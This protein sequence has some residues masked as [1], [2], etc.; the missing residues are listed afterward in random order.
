MAVPIPNSVFDDVGAVPVIESCR[1]ESWRGGKLLASSVPV[2]SGTLTGDRSLTVPEQVTLTVPVEVDGVRWDPL[3]E[4]DPLACYGQQ[5]RIAV[6]L[7]VRRKLYWMPRAPVVITGTQRDGDTIT[8][9]ASS[10][11]HLVSEARL[12][13]PLQP[14]AGDTLKKLAR[15]LVEPGLPVRFDDALVDRAVPTSSLQWDDDRIGALY[16]LAGAW[17]AELS[18]HRDGYLLFSPPV[19]YDLDDWEADVREDVVRVTAAQ[20]RDGGVNCV[21]ARG[22]AADGT[23]VQGVAYDTVST[24]PTRY[25]GPFSP[26]PVPQFFDSPLL[27]TTAQCQAAARTIMA[28]RRRA[29]ARSVTQD[30]KPWPGHE[31]GDLVLARDDRV[32]DLVVSIEAMTMPLTAGDG[33][34]SLALAVPSA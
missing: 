32:G 16:E 31:L 21:V 2:V 20:T 18:V 29:V 6:G 12:V 30:M 28:K 7:V 13:T 11:L 17:P 33:A 23:Q 8:V 25:M 5:L 1:V 26:Y 15:R 9:T 19:T 22:T 24:S 14:K 3:E 34:M 10:L 27:T 4:D